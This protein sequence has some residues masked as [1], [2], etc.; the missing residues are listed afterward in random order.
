MDKLVKS[1]ARTTGRATDNKH[2]H[3]SC[4]TG[5]PTTRH[6]VR[7]KRPQPSASRND[8]SGDDQPWRIRLWTCVARGRGRERE[9]PGAV[10]YVTAHSINS[11]PAGGGGLQRGIDCGVVVAARFCYFGQY[12]ANICPHIRSDAAVMVQKQGERWVAGGS[13]FAGTAG[14]YRWCCTTCP[15]CLPRRRRSIKILTEW[16]SRVACA[17]CVA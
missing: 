4:L 10:R 1:T 13:R 8:D 3:A 14:A 5:F 12:S 15:A 7:L 9:G 11:P 6:S 2:L 17:L 16:G